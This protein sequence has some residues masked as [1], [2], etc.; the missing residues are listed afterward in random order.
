M[1]PRFDTE[2]EN[3]ADLERLT[4]YTSGRKGG[5]GEKIQ[6]VDLI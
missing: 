6:V 4:A 5:K 1:S 2:H 3:L